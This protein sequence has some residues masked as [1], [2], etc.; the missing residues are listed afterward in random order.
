MWHVNKKQYNQ[1]EDDKFD[2][3][4]IIRIYTYDRDMNFFIFFL[5][6]RFFFYIRYWEAIKRWDEAIQL[7]PNDE[8]LYEMKAQVCM[9]IY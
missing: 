7:T 9:N 5:L 3:V 1:D 8:K 4:R 2:T 6:I